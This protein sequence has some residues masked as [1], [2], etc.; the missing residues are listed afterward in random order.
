MHGFPR[1]SGPVA[2][3]AAVTAALACTALACTALACTVTAGAGTALAAQR[4]PAWCKPGGTLSAR[5]MPQKVKITDC[6][7]RGRT[8]RG[9]NGLAAVVPSDGTSLVAHAMRTTGGAELRIEVDGRAGAV[10]ISTKG[11]R[12]PEGRPRAS[13][14]PLDPCEDGVHRLEPSK[15]PKGSTVEWRYHPGTSGLPKT[16]IAEGVS[17]MVDARTDCGNGDRF[18]PPP[19]VG[20]RDAGRSDGPPNVTGDAACGNRNRVN[21]FG[22]LAMTGAERDILAATCIWYDGET[23]VETDMALQERGKTWWSD[24][25]CQSGAY[26]AEAVAT[27]EAGHVFGLDHVEGADHV[28][29]TM[30]PSLASCDDGPATL[31]KGDYD[32]LIA[33]YGGR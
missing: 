9:A 15:W 25:T 5:A 18:T 2:A 29:L 8:V 19:D 32:G 6:D 28:N 13:R 27:H 3:A 7:L 11:G 31:G 21:T 17:N 16:G 4:S 12:V 14:A 23:T 30:T 33:L 22:W 10:T 1:A 24:G 20:A 26:S